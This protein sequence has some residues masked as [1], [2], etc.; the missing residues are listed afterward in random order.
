MAVS[1]LRTVGAIGNARGTPLHLHYGI[2]GKDGV[3]DPVPLL[4]VHRP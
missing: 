3:H 1:P 2:Y 4:K